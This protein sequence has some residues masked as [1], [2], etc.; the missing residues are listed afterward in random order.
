MG[1][2]PRVA[3]GEASVASR[4]GYLPSGPAQRSEHGPQP[5]RVIK[6]TI[7]ALGDGR[8]IWNPRQRVDTDDDLRFYWWARI[9]W[10][11]VAL[12]GVGVLGVPVTIASGGSHLSWLAVAIVV[13]CVVLGAKYCVQLVR[14]AWRFGARET[15][16]G[17]E[18]HEEPRHAEWAWADVAGFGYARLSGREVVVAHA[19]DGSEIVVPGARRRMRWNGGST[20]DFAAL[21]EERR[22]QFA[23]KALRRGE[24]SPRVALCECSIIYL[25]STMQPREGLALASSAHQPPSCTRAAVVRSEARH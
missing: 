7:R 14:L 4:S 9:R 11:S 3:R 22:Q 17:F 13:G 5:R 16:N 19:P 1:S 10:L 24:R 12:A 25:M 20:Q 23:A 6:H 8:G 15:A 21:M 18:G 2:Y